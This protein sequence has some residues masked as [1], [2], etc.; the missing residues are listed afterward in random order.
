MDE[1]ALLKDKAKENRDAAIAKARQDYKQSLAYIAELR[2]VMRNPSC[3]VWR[4]PAPGQPMTLRETMIAVLGDRKMT[5]IELVV[6]VLESGYK[7]KM[8]KR[9]VFRKVAAILR[10]D[11]RFK[12]QGDKWATV[13]NGC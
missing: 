1:F 8:P 12:R 7:T 9:E 6:S 10:K 4:D 13:T 3:K 11:G 2:K 5:K